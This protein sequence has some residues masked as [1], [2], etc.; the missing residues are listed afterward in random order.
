MASI[1]PESYDQPVD[2]IVESYDPSSTVVTVVT[3][4]VKIRNLTVTPSTEQIVS[5][6]QNVYIEEGKGKP[7]PLSVPPEDLKR[8]ADAST[9]SGTIAANF[10]ACGAAV[11]TL[12]PPPAEAPMAPPPRVCG[13]AGRGNVWLRLSFHA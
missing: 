5:S 4:R 6:C 8:L 11:S 1:Q 3:G 12:P 2:F 9:I 10:D 13:P 7:E